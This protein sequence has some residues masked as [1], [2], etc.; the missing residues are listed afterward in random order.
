[1]VEEGRLN[2]DPSSLGYVALSEPYKALVEALLGA[3]LRRFKDKLVSLV[4]Y[5]SVARGEAR[6]DSDVDLLIVIEDLPKS[7]LRRQD[8]FMEVEEELKPL[9]EEL[10]AKGLNVDFTPILKTPDEASKITPLYLDMAEDAVIIY[11]KG[12]FFHQVLERLK[13]RLRELGAYRAKL[14]KRWFWVLKR[15]YVPGELITIE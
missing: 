13:E 6:P 14:G 15:D 4:V 8:L 11:D 5:G 7:R 3:L 2:T 1:M 9:I 10:R 12:G